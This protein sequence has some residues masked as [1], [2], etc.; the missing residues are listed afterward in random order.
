MEARDRLVK[1]IQ[2]LPEFWV[3]FLQSAYRA[4]EDSVMKQEKHLDEAELKFFL[5]Q[6]ELS[7][8]VEV[9]CCEIATKT[10]TSGSRSD[11]VTSY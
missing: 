7:S 8:L 10:E 2:A 5:C 1:E 6:P 4:L 11:A 3:G 9:Y